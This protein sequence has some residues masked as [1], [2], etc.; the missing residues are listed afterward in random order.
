MKKTVT[1][2]L[3][4]MLSMQFAMAQGITSYQYR[5]VA[6]ADMEEYLKRETTYW[7][8]WAEAEVKKGNLLF[9]GIFQRVGG[10][11]QEEGSNILIINE[12]K[13]IDKGADWGGIAAMFPNVKMEDIATWG[14]STDRA[15]IFLRGI[16]HIQGATVNPP[17]DFNYVRIIYHNTKDNVAH[18]AFEADKWKP[19][20]EK[21]MKEGKTTMKGWGNSSVI[22]PESNDFPY[23]SVSYD[24]FST[25]Q[26]ALSPAFNADMTIP[27]GFFDGLQANYAGP[28]NSNVFRIVTVVTPTSSR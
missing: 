12:F 19:L 10:M 24:L 14:I 3:L 5:R 11:N 22:S 9:W 8:K 26:D 20:V 21:A 28:R 15:N 27:D 2:V 25:L 16:N 13:D 7:K 6:P 4:C 18:L 17:T 1:L 23:S